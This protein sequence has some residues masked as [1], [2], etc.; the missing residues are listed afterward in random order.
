MMR[1]PILLPALLLSGVTA[2]HAIPENDYASTYE[3]VVVP[4]LSSGQRF[5]FR[6][7]DGKTD[8]QGI[9]FTHPGA[10][11]VI[12]VV[13]GKPKRVPT[14]PFTIACADGVS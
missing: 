4:F 2:L 11:G 12:V 10:K 14:R 5:T 8:L 1:W 9:R 13:N 7:A 6:S 3:K